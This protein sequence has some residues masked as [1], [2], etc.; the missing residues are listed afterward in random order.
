MKI[1]TDIESKQ[2][3]TV[4]LTEENFRTF[5]GSGKPLFVDFWAGWCLPCKKMD[6]LIT[7][8]AS[9]YDGRIVFGKVNVEEQTNIQLQ[10]Q[11]FSIPRS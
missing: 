4:T 1:K 8:L 5:S 10:Y 9:K 6:P 2:S 3:Q 7:N 11:V